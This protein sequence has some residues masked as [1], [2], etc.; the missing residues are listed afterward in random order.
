MNRQNKNNGQR[1]DEMRNI[2]AR[3]AYPYPDPGWGK[4]IKP[5]VKAIPS[6]LAGY[7]IFSSQN[8]QGLANRNN[9]Q[10]RNFANQNNRQRNNEIRNLAARSPYSQTFLNQNDQMLISNSQPRLNKPNVRNNNFNQQDQQSWNQMGFSARSPK[11]PFRGGIKHANTALNVYSAGSAIKD[12][13]NYF[14][15]NDGNMRDM[16]SNNRV[17]Q[18]DAQNLI[19]Q[20]TWNDS[21]ISARSPKR[22]GGGKVAALDKFFGYVPQ[23]IGGAI[24]DYFQQDGN[25]ENFDKQ[26]HWNQPYLEKRVGIDWSRPRPILEREDQEW[27]RYY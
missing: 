18:R 7:E 12:A 13:F 22:P 25:Y 6:I 15:G 5:F 26:N 10:Q 23:L 16:P 17:Y 9:L 8:D 11:R 24:G 27:S 20:Q 19:A 4:A 14:R 1:N 21:G 3:S 2:A